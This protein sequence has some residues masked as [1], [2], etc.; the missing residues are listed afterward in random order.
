MFA[1]VLLI[2]AWLNSMAVACGISI[3]TEVTYRSLALFEPVTEVQSAYKSI[4][5]RSDGYV[6]A[7][8][9]FPDWGY[10][11][12]GY[13]EEAEDA[14]WAPFI[15]TAI[16]YV[17]ETYPAP[18]TSGDPHVEGLVSFIFAIMSHDVA[19]VRWHS[20]Q[21]LKDYFIEAMAHMDFGG[22][23]S[24]AHTAAD[25]GA[26]F[27][28]QHSTRLNYINA[29]WHVPVRDIV[30]IYARLYKNDANGSRRIPHQDHLI[31]CMTT[32]FAASRIDLEF[33]RFLFG[34][35]GSKSPFLIE[36]LVDHYKGGLQDMSASIA[37]C[38]P[39]IIEALERN[40]SDH[41]TL[42]GSYFDEDTTNNH[43]K[44]PI[45]GVHHTPNG[46][47]SDDAGIQRIINNELIK[48]LFDDKHGTLS[49]SFTPTMTSA[50][51]DKI[52]QEQE[53]DTLPIVLDINNN[54]YH[55]VSAKSYDNRS[56]RGNRQQSLLFNYQQSIPSSI[57][58]FRRDK[59]VC[60]NLHQ[61]ENGNKNQRRGR[62]DT[63]DMSSITLSLPESSAAIGHATTIG[64]LDGDGERE[65]IISAP[66]HGQQQQQQELMSGAVFVLNGTNTLL[67]THQ[68]SSLIDDIRNASRDVLM[69][70]HR[71]G[72][73]GWSMA[74]VDLNGDGIDD[75]AVA[76][77]FA[78]DNQG[79]VDIFYGRKHLGIASSP[80]VRIEVP[81]TEGFGF[82]VA[83][84]DIDADGHKDLVVG[85]PY[86]AVA[87]K[88]QA[89][90]V[91]IFLSSTTSK[92]NKT[93]TGRPDISIYNTAPEPYEHFGSAL[94]FS[95]TAKIL[96]VGA[97]G[98][99]NNDNKKKKNVE[100]RA[101][102]VYAFR[103]YSENS[104][105]VSLVWTMA[106]THRFQHFGSVITL[107][108][109]Q[110]LLAVSSPSEETK[111]GIVRKWQAGTVRVYDWTRLHYEGGTTVG[112]NHH[113]VHQMNGQDSAGHLG[114]SLAFFDD[115]LWVGEPMANGERGRV[116]RWVFKDNSVTCMI[117]ADTM[118]PILFS[119]IFS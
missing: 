48:K 59:P 98:C 79:H 114:H 103:V 116:H 83:G 91:Y 73:F 41:K 51:I 58:E 115:G 11:C 4:M 57:H 95:S 100:E 61:G 13:N 113:L 36:E 34:Y 47:S 18:R 56:P 81:N 10:Q 107:D 54:K 112:M 85:C 76:A 102:R 38:H 55:G 33:G 12:M 90:A 50:S 62:R 35:Y 87:G 105:W 2:A 40:N 45:R 94:E 21:G 104:L 71:R 99:N 111:K 46:R 67:N 26:E 69:G 96:L 15:R 101:G 86:C 1:T 119:R 110:R 74:T 27:T 66:Y 30:N 16:D 49:L 6:Q 28:L 52:E 9:F 72:R 17:K 117:N 97:P 31:Y 23:Y 70:T 64:D 14:H 44:K 78:N 84:L 60:V 43:D 42:C 80:D 68:T 108:R 7:G 37:E 109:T 3:H 75:L 65:L 24:K 82:V 20:L 22:D 89:G 118:V 29:T 5:E 39:D 25:T 88:Q 63:E 106:G 19:D 53:R 32:A 92:N 93:Y 8:S 77:P